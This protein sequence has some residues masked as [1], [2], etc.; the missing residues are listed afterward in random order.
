MGPALFEGSNIPEHGFANGAEFAAVARRTWQG[1][2]V[3]N[4]KKALFGEKARD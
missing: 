4:A 3:D 2:K 1:W